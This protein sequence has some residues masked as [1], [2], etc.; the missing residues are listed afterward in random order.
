MLPLNET[1]YYKGIKQGIPI[2]QLEIANEMY[3]MRK[4]FNEIIYCLGE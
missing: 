2:S 4:K 3:E 1:I